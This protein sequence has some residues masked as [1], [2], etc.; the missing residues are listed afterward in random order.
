MVNLSS[1]SDNPKPEGPW[2]GNLTLAPGIVIYAGP[3][4]KASPH[5][6]H[7]IQFIR[8]FTEPFELVFEDETVSCMSAIVPSGV[9]HGFSSDAER[10]LLALIEP[11]GPR[12][13]DL[14]ELALT[15][16]HGQILTRLPLPQPGTDEPRQILQQSIEALLPSR[17]SYPHI[18]RHVEAALAYLDE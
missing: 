12:G 8:S 1:M 17:P 9:E 3:G 6:H 7:A 2:P 16:D 4:G 5:S 10:L 11:L 18:S 13:A 14:N 15:L